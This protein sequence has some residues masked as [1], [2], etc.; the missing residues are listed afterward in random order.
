[1]THVKRKDEQYICE[2]STRNAC[3]K[4]CPDVH[5][6][7]PFLWQVL[8]AEIGWLSMKQG[9][10]LE[11]AYSNPANLYGAIQVI[12]TQPADTCIRNSTCYIYR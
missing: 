7:F 4:Q 5:H 2:E 11:K 9:E 3:T 1:M 8:H 6:T 12:N 10:E